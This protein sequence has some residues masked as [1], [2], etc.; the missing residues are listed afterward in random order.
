MREQKQVLEEI[1]LI[2][3]KNDV[4]IILVCGDIFDTYIPSAEA[5]DLFYET[6]CRMSDSGQRLVAVIAGNHDDPVRL[7]AAS[8]L[9]QKHAIIISGGGDEAF[10]FSDSCPVKIIN[11]GR[12][13]A[14]VQTKNGEKALLNYLAYPSDSRLG[15]FSKE[16]DYSDKI[17]NYLKGGNDKFSSDTVN[18]TLSHLFAAGAIPTGEEREIQLGGI[19]VC[20]MSVFSDKCYTALGHIHKHQKMGNN[21]YYS[22]SIL[23]YSVDESSNKSVILCEISCSGSKS[24]EKIPLLSGKKVISFEADSFAN[25]VEFLSK[26]N[27]YVYLTIRQNQPLTYQ[28]SKEL[29]SFPNLLCIDLKRNGEEAVLNTVSKKNYSKRE[30]FTNYYTFKYNSPPPDELTNL[31]LDIIENE[32]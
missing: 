4:D 29:K 17:S 6:I 14:A 18:I 7:C 11:S 23:Q 15:E 8:A 27:D 32:N 13:Y 21:I 28:E 9:A 20:S 19:K 25:A 2:A 3:E 22:G 12:G 30:L 16:I 1:C 10:K 24:I 5:E 26:T 31:F